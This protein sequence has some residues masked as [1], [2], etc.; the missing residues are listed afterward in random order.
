MG[1]ATIMKGLRTAALVGLAVG[2]L[3][4]LVGAALRAHEENGR[5]VRRLDALD[6]A[7]EGL[8]EDN[9]RLRAEVKASQTD[10]VYVENRLRESAKAGEGE[11][12]IEK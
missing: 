12:L 11:K 1:V 6:R 7:A 9:A 8:R 5:H 3:A 2:V 10:P 4:V